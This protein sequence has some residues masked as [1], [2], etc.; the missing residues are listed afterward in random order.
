[1]D[2]LDIKRTKYPRVSEIIGKQNEAELK[3]IPLEN[4]V[5]ASIRGTE[6]HKL[7]T[8]FVENAWIDEISP[9][10]KPYLD[11]FKQWYENNATKRVVS[12]QRLY[13]DKKKFTGEV[14]MILDLKNGKRCLLDIKTS[15]TR[16]KTWPV[17]LAAYEHLCS[18]NDFRVDIVLNL[19]LKAHPAAKFEKNE[20]G[21]KVLISPPSV[22]SS[23]CVY[24]NLNEFWGIFASALQ[25]YDYFN[26]KESE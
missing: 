2:E 11:S 9:E 18:I 7:C 8:M 6:I 19:H 24:E 14:D 5:N 17:Q 15:S 20:K 21:E 22:K 4:L 16:S 3:S 1:M 12:S 25:C 23:V 10:H 13:D 26:R